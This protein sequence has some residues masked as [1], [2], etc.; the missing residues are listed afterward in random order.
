MTLD[1]IRIYRANKK[2]I[3]LVK[4]NIAWPK[5]GGNKFVSIDK[6]KEWVDIEDERFIN[7]MMP[8]TYPSTYKGWFRLS[9]DEKEI[10][11]GEYTFQVT[12]HLDTDLFSGSK[13]FGFEEYTNY[14]AKNYPLLLI[15]ILVC[16]VSTV[17]TC[18]F[19]VLV[20]RERS[21]EKLIGNTA[22]KNIDL[23]IMENEV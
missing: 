22:N 1:D 3:K 17:F 12:N 7:W 11:A 14:G 9:P 16:I 2:E 15:L 18:A 5:L 23:P 6:D 4:T 13:Y 8:S 21:I 19:C 10:P 20:H